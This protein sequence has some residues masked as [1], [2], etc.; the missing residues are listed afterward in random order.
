MLVLQSLQIKAQTCNIT[1]KI[2]DKDSKQSM[3]GVYVKI[4]NV[5]DSSILSLII[6]E[7]DRSFN[8]PGLVDGKQFFGEDPSVTLK[9]FPAE[10]ID[11]VQVF[12]KLSE[13]AELTGFD[14]GN[15]QKTINL[16]TKTNRRNGLFG[17]FS[18]GSDLKDDLSDRFTIGANTNYFKGSQRITYLGL[19]NNLNVQNFASQDLVGA[20]GGGGRNFVMPQQNGI[21]T[22][23][24]SGLN[25]TNQNKEF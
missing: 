22:T 13:Q 2:L 10:V 12:N 6:T 21:T 24:S 23:G 4:R 18:A 7:T 1:G 15:S 19:A 25:Y 17:K 5:P 14:D 20:G 9:N 8:I 16:V 11:K 3:A